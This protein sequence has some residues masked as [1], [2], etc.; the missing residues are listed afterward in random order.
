MNTEEEE[1][2]KIADGT[3]YPE[4]VK[5]P[6]SKADDKYNMPGDKREEPIEEPVSDEKA[7]QAEYFKKQNSSTPTP[8]VNRKHTEPIEEPEVEV[9]DDPIPEPVIEPITIEEL[10][11]VFEDNRK[12]IMS[13]ISSMK[14]R[15]KEKDE[16][17][18]ILRRGNADLFLIDM[19]CHGENS[20]ECK[21]MLFSIGTEDQFRDIESLIKNKGINMAFNKLMRYFEDAR[22]TSR[23][24]VPII[25]AM[26]NTMNS[27]SEKLKFTEEA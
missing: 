16:Q 24:I 18:D 21:S 15:I 6:K 26:D 14:S 5:V 2:E 7:K 20:S 17:I 25:T 3:P 23:E 10:K 19:Q 22:T 4:P 8:I 12:E 1:L 9:E 11:I 27:F 13:E